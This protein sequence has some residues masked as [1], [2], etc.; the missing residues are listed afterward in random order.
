MEHWS[1][2]P[3]PL[4][5]IG[6]SKG[7]NACMGAWTPFTSTWMGQGQSEI[8]SEALRLGINSMGWYLWLQKV[9]KRRIFHYSCKCN[10][11]TYL[12]FQEISL[13]FWEGAPSTELLVSLTKTLSFLSP[14]CTKC[15]TLPAKSVT[16]KC[17]VV[18]KMPCK[19]SNNTKRFLHSCCYCQLFPNHIPDI[20]LTP[21]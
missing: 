9:W 18:Q 7:R 21:T 12:K 13:V 2:H 5:L 19:H 15:G 14:L 8:P 11:S 3:V 4:R 16:W 10:C 6:P 20:K 17:F 1:Q